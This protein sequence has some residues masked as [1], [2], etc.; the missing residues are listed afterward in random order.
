MDYPQQDPGLDA[1]GGAG[2]QVN[3]A[4]AQSNKFTIMAYDD[5]TEATAAYNAAQARS[6]VFKYPLNNENDFLGR[7]TFQIVDEEIERS[8]NP[9]FSGVGKA[10]WEAIQ[11]AGDVA[12]EVL[13]AAFG[14]DR[15][16]RVGADTADPGVRTDIKTAEDSFYG[17]GKGKVKQTNVKPE[18]VVKPGQK[19]TLY[20]PQAIQIQDAASYEVGVELGALGGS[21]ESALLSGRSVGS[22]I[23]A[24]TKSSVDMLKSLI[25][26]DL[27]K[28]SSEQASLAAAKIAAKVP[29]GGDAAA[30]AIRSATGVTTSPNV[31]ALFKSV[32]IRNF[33]FSF[34]LIPTSAREAMEIRNIIKFFRTELYPVQFDVGGVTYGY[35]FPNRFLIKV[36]YRNNDIPGI[37]FLPMYLQSFNAVYNPNGM[38]MHSD[39]SFSEF[40]ITMSFTEGTALN[41]QDVE[42]GGY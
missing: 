16:E 32:P 40:Q 7:I 2:G 14:G 21:V 10:T 15:E 8:I 39:G 19:V 1:F 29:I 33:S 3:Q 11:G 13:N 4:N 36:R 35:K 23:S 17:L 9:D 30:A 42:E 20:L 41:R 18:P 34:T 22:A 6:R 37:K 26:G 24:G 38:G 27:S 28:I 31:R 5:P 25:S 12:G